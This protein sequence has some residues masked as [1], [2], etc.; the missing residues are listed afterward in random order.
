MHIINLYIDTFA[1][2]YKSCNN[3]IP[4]LDRGIQY[5]QGFS[6]FRI[7]SGMTEKGLIEL[8]YM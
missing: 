6:G 4:R 5:F 3:V 1:K 2:H 8:S 7:K